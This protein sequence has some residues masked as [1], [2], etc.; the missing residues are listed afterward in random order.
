MLKSVV[1]WL[2]LEDATV[3]VADLG[4]GHLVCGVEGEV[5]AGLAF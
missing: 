4:L 1:L 2:G 5:L 3:R